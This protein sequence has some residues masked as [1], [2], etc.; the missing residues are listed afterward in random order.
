MC[1]ERDADAQN[2]IVDLRLPAALIADEQDL[3]ALHVGDVKLRAKQ[4]GSPNARMRRRPVCG[5]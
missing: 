2:A 5:E 3:R 1:V 4:S